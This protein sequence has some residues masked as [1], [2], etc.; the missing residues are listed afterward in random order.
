MSH[1]IKTS[2]DRYSVLNFDLLG[3]SNEC[4]ISKRQGFFYF[5]LQYS[6]YAIFTIYF[7]QIYILNIAG[8]NGYDFTDQIHNV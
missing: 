6:Q 3:C 2:F 8:Y 1:L 4:S 7:I 5:L